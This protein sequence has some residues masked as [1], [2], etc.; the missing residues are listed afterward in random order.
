MARGRFTYTM[1]AKGRLAIPQVMRVELQ[2]HSKRPPVL[3]NLV[4]A[5]A[6]GLYSAERWDEIETR[7]SNLSQVEPDV[8]SMSRLLISGAQECPFDGQGRLL[9]PAD[10]R[11]YAE[12]DRDIVIAGVG[13]RIEIWNKTRFERELASAKDRG[14][15][16]ARIAAGLG[17]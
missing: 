7:L 5:A 13:A 9:V 3:T 10:L 16:L 4:G 17:L 14:G 8:Q 1:D 11:E 2:A 6:L 15:D 12:L